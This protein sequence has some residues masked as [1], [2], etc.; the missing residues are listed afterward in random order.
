[1]SAG[2]GGEVSNATVSLSRLDPDSGRVT[3]TV[4]LR[5]DTGVFPVAGAPRIAV[6]AGAVWAANPDGSVSRI[7]PDTGRLE[8]TIETDLD[9][10]T[11]AAGDEGVWFLGR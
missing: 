11:I 8:A 5:G 7:D 6:G 2:G 10:F 1:M 4:R 9:A 3:Q